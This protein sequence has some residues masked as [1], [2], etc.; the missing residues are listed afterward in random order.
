MRG[1]LSVTAHALTM[2]LV[3]MSHNTDDNES[4]SCDFSP[5]AWYEMFVS[6]CLLR[7]KEYRQAVATSGDWPPT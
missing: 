6:H 4:E 5:P 2:I 1:F 7:V 3:G